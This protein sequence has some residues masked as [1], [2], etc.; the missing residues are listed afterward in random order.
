MRVS[1][2]LEQCSR[3]V[4]SVAMGLE[5]NGPLPCEILVKNTVLQGS[6]SSKDL[7]VPGN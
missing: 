1:N 6:V 3:Q 2:Y 4:T 7:L 5:E